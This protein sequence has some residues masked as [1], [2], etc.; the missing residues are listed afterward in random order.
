MKCVTAI[1]FFLKSD[2][3]LLVEDKLA[4][5]TAAVVCLGPKEIAIMRNS[6]Q[7]FPVLATLKKDKSILTPCLEYWLESTGTGQVLSN[8]SV[9]MRSGPLEIT[10]TDRDDVFI[11][12]RTASI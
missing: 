11:P 12:T 1:I 5:V 6:D 10:I 9:V 8:L 2:S 7:R 4:G 3:Y